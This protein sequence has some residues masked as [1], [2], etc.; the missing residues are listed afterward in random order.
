MCAWC[1]VRLM[2][3]KDELMDLEQESVEVIGELLQ[4]REQR[5]GW[6]A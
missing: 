4:V 1:Q 3:L 5:R 6:G 2:A